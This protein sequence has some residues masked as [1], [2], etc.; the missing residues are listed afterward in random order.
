M[1]RRALTN[2]VQQIGEA[3]ARVS[4]AGRR[5]APSVPWGQ[6]V[7]MRHILVHV[8]WGVDHDRLWVTATMDVPQLVHALEQACADWPMPSP[9]QP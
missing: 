9:P 2:A 3:A 4:D 6:I 7:A 5:R 8:H 1:L